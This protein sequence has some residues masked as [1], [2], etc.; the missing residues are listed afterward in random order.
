MIVLIVA[1]RLT[2]IRECDEIIV[3]DQGKILESGSH[4]ELMRLNGL[5]FGM[6][7]L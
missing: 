2:T 4:E 1:H 7:N 5:Y 6:N 3:L